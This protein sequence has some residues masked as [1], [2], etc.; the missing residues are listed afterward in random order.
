[1]QPGDSGATPVARPTEV[2]VAEKLQAP[3]KKPKGTRWGRR[4]WDR[5][6]TSTAIHGTHPMGWDEL[7]K[8]RPARSRRGTPQ[9]PPSQD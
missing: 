6:G 2:T 3:A 8:P 9:G 7:G 5:A 1:M 4:R